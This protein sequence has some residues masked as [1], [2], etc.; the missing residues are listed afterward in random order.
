[1]ACLGSDG[2][3]FHSIG[4][5]STRTAGRPIRAIP[6]TRRGERHPE[7]QDGAPPLG[8]CSLKSVKKQSV[9][10]SAALEG[11]KLPLASRI[12]AANDSVVFWA[13]GTILLPL[14]NARGK[15]PPVEFGA[16]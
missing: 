2:G 4:C 14:I 13:A 1:M 8:Y 11:A 15:P 16:V 5:E 7:C 12:T 6:S 3:T 10:C 9:I